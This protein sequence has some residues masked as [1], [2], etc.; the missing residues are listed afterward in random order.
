MYNQMKKRREELG[1][2]LQQLADRTGISK[3]TL[4]RYETGV[5]KKIPQDAYEKICR[6]LEIGMEGDIS[7]LLEE[8]LARLDSDCALMFDGIPIDERTRDLLQISIRNSLEMARSV[9]EQRKKNE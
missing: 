1:L 9:S 5:T 6:V 8:S 2:S 4:Q 3:A 7:A